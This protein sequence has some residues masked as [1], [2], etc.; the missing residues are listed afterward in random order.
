MRR[1]PAAPK[2]DGSEARSSNRFDGGCSD[3][4]RGGRWSLESRE[5][6]DRARVSHRSSADT[7]MN[8]TQRSACSV[9]RSARLACQRA[10]AAVAG[11]TVPVVAR[12][13]VARNA[14]SSVFHPF[15][16][17]VAPPLRWWARWIRIISDRKKR[18][19]C[20]HLKPQCD[21]GEG[22]VSDAGGKQSAGG[23]CLHSVGIRPAC[24]V[25]AGGPLRRCACAR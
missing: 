12:W 13:L 8:R 15:T 3:R 25:R 24:A 23:R 4:G 5:E 14:A 1:E 10:A 9:L 20:A 2:R 11:P 7:A 17:F 19:A 6:R 18:R 22:T 21:R 16:R